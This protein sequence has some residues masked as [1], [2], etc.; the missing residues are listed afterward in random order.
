MG[1]F[2]RAYPPDRWP[3]V[4]VGRRGDLDPGIDADL[5]AELDRRP[6]GTWVAVGIAIR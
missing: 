4:T 6:E 5:I 3:A 1:R 2:D